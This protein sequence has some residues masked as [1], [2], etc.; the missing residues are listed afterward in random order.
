MKPT[1][2]RLVLFFTRK[3]TNVLYVAMP[4]YGFLLVL[5]VD[6]FDVHGGYGMLNPALLIL[7][8]LAEWAKATTT[9]PPGYYALLLLLTISNLIFWVP[10]ARY[11][12]IPLL[13]R[14]FYPKRKGR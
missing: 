11:V 14:V 2:H 5:L 1:D 12:A 10:M 13:D 3:K 6:F 9:I 8:F 4:A 7:L